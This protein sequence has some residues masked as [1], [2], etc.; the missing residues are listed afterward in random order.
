MLTG[1]LA[2]S[3]GVAHAGMLFS[4][5]LCPDHRA[6]VF[7]LASAAVVAAG[8]AVA[9][10]ARGWASSALLTVVAALCGVAIGVIDIAHDP[11]RGRV[12]AVAF[13]VVAVAGAT[14]ALWHLRLHRWERATVAALSPLS[15]PEQALARR[16]S[17][18]PVVDAVPQEDAAM[19]AAPTI[20]G[21]D[22]TRRG[23]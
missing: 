11:S 2:V 6:W 9:G 18:E 19:S 12:I 5:T 3:L 1:S 13:G 17:S 23:Q 4:D 8:F 16:A 21:S 20:P 14:L 22:G 10:L 7:G 15:T